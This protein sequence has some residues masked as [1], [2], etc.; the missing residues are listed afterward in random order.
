MIDCANTIGITPAVLIRSGM[1]LRA[2]SRYAVYPTYPAAF[3]AMLP[4]LASNPGVGMNAGA[5]APGKP[6][7]AAVERFV[8]DVAEQVLAE[9]DRVS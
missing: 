4:Y 9:A 1:K 8:D 3:R 7:V 5:P 2:A 6:K